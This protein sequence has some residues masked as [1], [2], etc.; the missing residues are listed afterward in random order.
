VQEFF[1]RSI[2]VRRFQPVKILRC[3]LIQRCKSKFSPAFLAMIP[4]P[5]PGEEVIE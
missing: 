4:P 3:P 1:P 5:F 2:I